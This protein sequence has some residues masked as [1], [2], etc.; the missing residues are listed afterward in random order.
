MPLLEP[1]AAALVIGVSH[2]LGRGGYVIINSVERGGVTRKCEHVA[3]P[4]AK[5][6]MALCLR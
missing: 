6:Q 1:G 3:T 4:A 5:F 2:R